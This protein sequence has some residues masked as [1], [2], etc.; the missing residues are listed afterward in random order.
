MFGCAARI[1]ARQPLVAR[2]P[3]AALVQQL[4]RQDRLSRRHV[5]L[6]GEQAGV[7]GAPHRAHDEDLDVGQRRR[8]RAQR[9]R[10]LGADRRQLRV[11]KFVLRVVVDGVR[12]CRAV[13]AGL[14]APLA[15]DDVV[16]ALAVAHEVHPLLVR[17]GRVIVVDELARERER[18]P[19]ARTARSP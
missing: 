4:A 1:A 18:Q 14:G 10:L 8:P 2:V 7:G 5:R 16:R 17:A 13:P 3:P 6:E 12:L 11:A 15:L 9:L 19:P